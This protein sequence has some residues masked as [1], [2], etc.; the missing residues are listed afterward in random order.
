MLPESPSMLEARWVD[1]IHT[2][3]LVRYGAKWLNLFAGVDMDLVKQDWARELGR[4][5]A[6]SIKRAL[7][8]LPE[9]YPPNVSQFRALCIGPPDEKPAIP[10]SQDVNPKVLAEMKQIKASMDAVHPL[11]WARRL[12]QRESEGDRLTITQK[13]MWRDALKHQPEG[14]AA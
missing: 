12:Q 10:W 14:D 11:A 5:P 6:A 2:R 9:D 4:I 7:D 1:A 3:L 13:T 8:S